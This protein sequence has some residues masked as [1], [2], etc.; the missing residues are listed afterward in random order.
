[1][2]TDFVPDRPTITATV[3]KWMRGFCLS[4]RELLVL[5][6]VQVTTVAR[7]VAVRP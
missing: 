3:T 2:P 6:Y 7:A 5:E 1:M 4:Q